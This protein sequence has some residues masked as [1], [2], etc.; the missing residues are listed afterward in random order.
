MSP[1]GPMKAAAQPAVPRL[2]HAQYRFAD[3][4]YYIGRC[5][6]STE[7]GDI[8]VT[9][10]RLPP[11]VRYPIID[12]LFCIPVKAPENPCAVH[13]SIDVPAAFMLPCHRS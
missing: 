3:G 12:G 4:A 7:G 13:T 5:E 10:C 2:C 6:T 8:D 11:C 1:H 9:P